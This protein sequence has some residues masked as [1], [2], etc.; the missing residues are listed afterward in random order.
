MAINSG[1]DA[2]LQIGKGDTWA[3]TAAPTHALDFTSESLKFVPNYIEEDA[4]VGKVT[5]GR[6]D[7]SGVKVEGDFSM[8]VKPDNIGL[9]LKATFGV[10]GSSD[11]DTV[12][13]KAGGDTTTGD[14]AFDHIFH[15]VA[16]GSSGDLP[17]LQLVVDRKVNTIGYNGCKIDTMELAA[18]AQDYV[19]ATFSVIGYTE[20]TGDTID[21][22]LS[23]STLSAF[24]FKHGAV[25]AGTDGAEST[26]AQVTSF[27]LNY[28]N[29]L[30]N[31]LY[32]MESGDYMIEIQPQQ[33]EIT[34][35]LEVLYNSSTDSTRTTYFKTG[36][37]LS[38]VITF[39]H[40][41]L[42]DAA[43]YYMLILDMPQCYI[44]AADPV[45]SGPERITQTLTIKATE[46][47]TLNAITATLT[48]GDTSA[49]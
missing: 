39:T 26:Y 41:T 5:T 4:L 46:T 40:P 22:S 1:Q 45:V 20:D 11:G 24:Q 14:T 47:A 18:D 35:T 15:P 43:L 16:G 42:I 7:I 37:A 31:D 19:R 8:I 34:A 9:L 32:V 33:R 10:E 27:R 13:A 49:Y 12:S 2:K 28:S 38:V 3:Q 44:T 48:N 21:S 30:E 29:N 25:T 36:T 23:L 17:W 6:M